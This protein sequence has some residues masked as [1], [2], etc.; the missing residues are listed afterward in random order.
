[1]MIIFLL[2]VNGNIWNAFNLKIDFAQP[3]VNV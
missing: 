2:I 1:M 3:A